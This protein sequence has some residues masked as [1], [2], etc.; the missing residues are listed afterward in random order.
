MRCA[1]FVTLSLAVQHVMLVYFWVSALFI[2]ESG[3]VCKNGY[4]ETKLKIKNG[5]GYMFVMD[6]QELLRENFESQC[7]KH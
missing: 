6:V 7:D 4:C 2:F 1:L 3:I 5:N